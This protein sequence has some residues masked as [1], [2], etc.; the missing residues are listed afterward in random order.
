MAPLM[1]GKKNRNV[2]RDK[3]VGEVLSKGVDEFGQPYEIKIAAD[4]KPALNA[5][6]RPGSG[7][8]QHR[9]EAGVAKKP[10]KGKIAE[11]PVAP[12]EEETEEGGN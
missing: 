3:V 9:P 11:A 4:G 6:P 8:D 2:G 1:A 12:Q 5:K 10:T 7:D